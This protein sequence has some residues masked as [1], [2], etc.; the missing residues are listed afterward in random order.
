MGKDKVTINSLVTSAE[1]GY[2]SRDQ[3]HSDC[4]KSRMKINS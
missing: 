1:K 4:N 2:E 3:K